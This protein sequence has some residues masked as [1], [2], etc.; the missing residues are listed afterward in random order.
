[1][2][3]YM[4][5]NEDLGP[6]AGSPIPAIYAWRIT[7][8]HQWPHFGTT[9]KWYEYLLNIEWAGAYFVAKPHWFSGRHGC[10]YFKQSA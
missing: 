6:V 3:R 9:L 5:R 8:Y 1:M 2:S 4:R 7:A 10:Q